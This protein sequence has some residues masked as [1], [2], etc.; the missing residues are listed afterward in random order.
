MVTTWSSS[1]ALSF[2]MSM[3][4]GHL[5]EDPD[6]VGAIRARTPG[7]GE[8]QGLGLARSDAIVIIESEK[9]TELFCLRTLK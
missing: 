9:T 7:A 1:V 2:A 3:S 6:D 8:R 4:P 5:R